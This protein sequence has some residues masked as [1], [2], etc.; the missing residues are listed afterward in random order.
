[1]EKNNLIYSPAPH[2]HD[3]SSTS[4]IM[5]DVLIALAPSCIASVII[6][7]WKAL[8]LILS[9]V[10]TALVSETL[11]NL[12]VK[13]KNTISDL[14][15]AVTGVLLALNLSTDVKIWQA[16]VGTLFAILC[17]KLLFGGLG[18]NFVNPALTARV[19]ML[20]A[21]SS[22]T[23]FSSPKIVELA[24]SATPL[25]ILA[26]NEMETLPSLAN[27]FLGLHGGTI[28]ETCI[29]ALT[30]GWIY[31]SVRKVIKW[32]VPFSYILTV[33]VLFLVSSLSP[34]Y[35]LCE[36]L[37]GGLFLGAIFMATDYVTTP[38]T[39][40]GKVVFCICC[41]IL[42]FIIRRF[43]SLPE[44]VSFSIIIMNIFTPYIEKLTRTVPLGGGSK[45]GK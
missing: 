35:A 3:N 29:L 13:K 38:I 30:I 17:V 37:S 2:F 11:F 42:T 31:L 24:S 10:L 20:V 9:C 8:A 43:C 16:V 15:A 5:R 21:F 6:F 23:V 12:I 33:F 18:K 14:S 27:L 19:F 25:A 26:K 45:N 34:Y 44:G 7:S 28:G 36:I 22:V 4:S 32:Y 41:G 39:N 40:K 1:M